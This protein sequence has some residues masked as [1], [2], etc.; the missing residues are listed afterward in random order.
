M[1]TIMEGAVDANK[2]Y[3]SKGIKRGMCQ[4]CDCPEFEWLPSHALSICTY[5]GCPPAKHAKISI[6]IDHHLPST[7][8]GSFDKS[9]SKK[10]IGT[11]KSLLLQTSQKNLEVRIIF[12][13]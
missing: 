7:S 10:T 9:T 6:E 1:D 2:N 11:K 8:N 13:L 5:C 12:V 4:Q 3:D